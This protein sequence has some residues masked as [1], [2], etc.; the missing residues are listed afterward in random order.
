MFVPLL[1]LNDTQKLLAPIKEILTN[2][3]STSGVPI[4]N[5]DMI[6]GLSVSLLYKGVKW[7]EYCNEEKSSVEQTAE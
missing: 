7:P 4:Q 3:I 6:N 5:S 2:L 1:I